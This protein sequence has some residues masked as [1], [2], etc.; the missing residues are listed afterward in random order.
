MGK[1][2]K[3]KPG[4]TIAS[5]SESYGHFPGTI[6]HHPEN[7]DLRSKRDNMNILAEDDEVFI[8][9]IENKTCVCPPQMRHRFR[10]VGVPALYRLQLL[11]NGKPRKNLK[12]LFALD[13]QTIEGVTD[14]RGVIEIFI[15]PATP[16]LT[17]F[18]GDEE[19]PRIIKIGRLEPVD[20]ISGLQQRLRNLGYD[21]AV[22]G[23]LDE[24][25]RRALRSFQRRASLTVT[26]EADSETAAVLRRAHDNIGGQA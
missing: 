10:R 3:V 11:R 4:D 17:L 5:L 20:S 15:P 9:E 26:G 1:I 19:T 14:E 16:E 7:S 13:G 25:T 12:Y 8:P 24:P 2:H 23:T 22:S 18:L 21:C 6:W